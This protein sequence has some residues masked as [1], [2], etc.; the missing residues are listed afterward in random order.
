MILLQMLTPCF[1]PATGAKVLQGIPGMG[2]TSSPRLCTQAI[3]N[4][5]VVTPLALASSFILPT[6]FSFC[7]QRVTSA[8]TGTHPWISKNVFTAP[9]CQDRLVFAALRGAMQ[10]LQQL[11]GPSGSYSSS[12]SRPTYR[13]HILFGVVSARCRFPEVIILQLLGLELPCQQA[14]PHGGVRQDPNAQLAAQG[15]QLL[16]QAECKGVNRT[17]PQLL[18]GCLSLP[19]ILK[20]CEGSAEQQVGM[21]MRLAAG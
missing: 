2:T 7:V 20:L 8:C 10:L 3:A 18:E 6:A 13:L 17:P 21:Q 11:A 5:P 1:E 15:H 19:G 16:L 14:A 9:A 4:C 12:Y